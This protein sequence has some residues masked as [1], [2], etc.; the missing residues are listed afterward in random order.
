MQGLDPKFCIVSYA[1][2]TAKFNEN[3]SIV[4]SFTPLLEAA[5]N[6]VSDKVIEKKKIAPLFCEIYGF[7]I[8]LP[9]LDDLISVLER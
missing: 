1:V 2:V 6:K 7:N 5:L 4:E 8:P 9:I 3:K